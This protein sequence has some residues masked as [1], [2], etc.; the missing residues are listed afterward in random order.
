MNKDIFIWGLTIVGYRGIG[1]GHPNLID[2]IQLGKISMII[3]TPTKGRKPE[4]DGFKIRRKVV[5]TSFPCMTS[6]DKA[7]VVLSWVRKR[8]IWKC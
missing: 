8:M 7:K 2:L 6:L 3:N 5:E 1:L 4:R